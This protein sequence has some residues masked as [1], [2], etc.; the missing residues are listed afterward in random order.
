M[1]KFIHAADLHMDRSFEGLVGIDEKV[2]KK[3]LRANLTVLENIV[4]Q[5]IQH[6]VDFVLLVGDS[7]HQH[8][9][10]LK[11][12]KHFSEQIKRLAEQNIPVFLTFGNHDFYQKERY[13]FEFPENLSLFTSESVETQQMTT[14][15]GETV[16]LS[17]F[18]YTK[19]WITEE[20]VQ[21]FPARFSVDYHIGLYHGEIGTIQGNY[22][23]FQPTQMEAKGY[24]YWA[25]G[26]IHVP[27]KL[28]EKGTILYPGAPQGHTKKEE[29]STSV[30]LVE[31]HGATCQTTPLKVAEVYWERKQLSLKEVRE[32]TDVLKKIQQELIEPSTMTLVEIEFIDFEHLSQE[33]LERIHSGELLDYLK[34][35]MK[36]KF[37]NLVIWRISTLERENDAK[38]SLSASSLMFDQLFENYQAR[39]DFQHILQEAYTNQEAVKV[40][41]LLPDFQESTLQ[42]AQEIIRQDFLFEGDTE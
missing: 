33:I 12:Q 34:E 35:E 10:S 15:A 36:R 28:N 27:T 39:E 40:L 14:N 13:W 37:L 17:G 3:L 23:P 31:L 2:Q 26:H 25:L 1:V 38:I 8:R 24:D 42:K 22:A 41:N 4:E 6:Q 11:I 19:Q 18:S 7:F 16:A 9:P 20:K 5:A 21:E 32:T 29:S 30:V